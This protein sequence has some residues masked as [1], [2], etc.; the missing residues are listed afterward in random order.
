MLHPT[1]PQTEV[2]FGT[3]AELGKHHT[4]TIMITYVFGGVA[5]LPRVLKGHLL[6]IGL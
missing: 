2:T 5:A 4:R 6:K 3:G 1:L